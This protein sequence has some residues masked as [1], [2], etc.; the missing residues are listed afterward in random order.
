MTEGLKRGK[1]VFNEERM[2]SPSASI[3]QP[4]E[5]KVL[6]QSAFSL[7]KKTKQKLRYPSLFSRIIYSCQY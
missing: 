2:R 5:H 3:I 4:F 1:E 6:V 7:S